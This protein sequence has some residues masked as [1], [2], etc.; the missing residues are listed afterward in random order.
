MTE[1]VSLYEAVGG[2]ATFARLVDRFYAAVAAD[3]VLR[4]MHPEDLT[5]A[6]QRMTAFLVQ[7]WG[8][9]K[10]YSDLRGHPRLRMRHATFQIDLQARDRWLAAMRTALDHLA[11]PEEQDRTLWHYLQRTAHTLVNQ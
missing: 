6:R 7:Y 3:P 1:Q 10:D 4:P 11:L 5:G 8:G 2:Q 9:P